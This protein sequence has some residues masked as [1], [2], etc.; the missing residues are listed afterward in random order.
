MP[1]RGDSMASYVGAASVVTA[2]AGPVTG[3]GGTGT[4][5]VGGDVPSMVTA[6]LAWSVL[7]P[8]P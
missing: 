5:A 3:A 4:M 2:A 6:V 1:D 8:P 7:D